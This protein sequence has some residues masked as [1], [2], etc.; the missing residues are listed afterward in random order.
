MINRAEGK[1]SDGRQ[2]E[3]SSHADSTQAYGIFQQNRQMKIHD[4]PF[5]DGSLVG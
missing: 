5:V 3:P 4:A 2:L 1:A